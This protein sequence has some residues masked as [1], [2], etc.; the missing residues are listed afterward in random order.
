MLKSPIS[1]VGGKFYLRKQ[2]IERIPEHTCYVEVFGG[3]GWVL[4]AKEQCKSEVYNDLHG[5]LVNFFRVVK[6]RPAEFIERLK[7]IL[8]SRELYEVWYDSHD[9]PFDEVER[10]IRFFYK[11][12]LSFGGSDIIHSYTR[13]T[14]GKVNLDIGN[15]AEIL[16]PVHKRLSRVSIEQDDYENLFKVY[17][18]PHT[19]FFCDPPYFL[20]EGLYKYSF[21]PEDFERFRDAICNIKGKFLITLN[22]HP[23]VRRLFK[24]F[25]IEKYKL[26]YTLSK[27]PNR[28]KH[29][30]EI[31]I[32][33]Y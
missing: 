7:W 13:K 5:A 3:A 11:L 29:G 31:F 27:S 9:E 14:T 15:L 10:A 26:R 24:D 19:F 1:W 22:D 2:I 8:P 12:R 4:F 32:S 18:R 16:E 21:E 23:E 33:N 30:D 28:K 6:H 17:D 25:N 20:P